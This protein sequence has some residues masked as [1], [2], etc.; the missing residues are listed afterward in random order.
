MP[1]MYMHAR[2]ALDVI[3]KRNEKYDKKALLLGAQF[4]DPLYYAFF[5]KHR[6]ILKELADKAHNDNTKLLMELLVKEIKN[7]NNVKTKS[8]LTGI[9]C[10]Y[11]LDITIH[12]YVYHHVGVYDKDDGLTDHLRGLHLKFERSMDAALFKKDN[13]RFPKRIQLVH[14]YFP[15]RLVPKEIQNVIQNVFEERFNIQNG[16]SLY[17]IGVRHMRFILKYFATDRYGIKRSIYR[18]IDMIKHKEDFFLEDLSYYRKV[19]GFDYLN[20]QNRKWLH[21][22]NGNESYESVMS[23]YKNAMTFANSLLDD[24]WENDK[25]IDEIFENISLNTG[26]NCNIKE[27]FTFLN[28]YQKND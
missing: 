8:F 26:V 16:A 20:E 9:I 1:D 25:E 5:S 6:L 7:S 13:G 22:I 27:N 18:L 11:A 21:P 24:I 4:F 15:V 10:H 14:Y 3:Q 19:N 28:I 17:Q 12:P 2:H 23:L